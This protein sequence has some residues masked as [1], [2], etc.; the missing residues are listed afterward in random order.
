MGVVKRMILWNQKLKKIMFWQK[1]MNLTKQGAF[2]KNIN[3]LI[4]LCFSVIIAIVAVLVVFNKIT[5]VVTILLRCRTI[6]VNFITVIVIKVQLTRLYTCFVWH[7]FAV[8][9][10]DGQT[11]TFYENYALYIRPFFSLRSPRGMMVYSIS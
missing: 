5:Y 4:F 3:T 1:R 9:K 8:A 11:Q 10:P 6:F 2:E 7:I